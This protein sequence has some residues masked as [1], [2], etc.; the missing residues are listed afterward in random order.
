M[1]DRGPRCGRAARILETGEAQVAHVLT[2]ICARVA[3]SAHCS[4]RPGA[5][6]Q[7]C[8]AW[9][10][11]QA[12]G[13]RLTETWRRRD[14]AQGGVASLRDRSRSTTPDELQNRGPPIRVYTRLV[15]RAIERRPLAEHSL[16]CG[17]DGLLDLGA[18][19]RQLFSE[20]SG[21]SLTTPPLFKKRT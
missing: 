19:I 9:R 15:K 12:P 7:A 5:V 14:L 3:M 8:T 18:D 17:R 13:P 4:S 1:V 21:S 10:S 20:L 11:A 2:T 6:A 16:S